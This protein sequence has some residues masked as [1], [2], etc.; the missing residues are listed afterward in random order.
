MP[1]LN[2]IPGPLKVGAIHIDFD[3]PAPINEALKE[4]STC[5]ANKVAMVFHPN[6]N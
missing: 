2:P 5:L 6:E 3:I 1:T 4:I